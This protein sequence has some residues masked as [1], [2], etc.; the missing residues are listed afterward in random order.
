MQLVALAGAKQRAKDVCPSARESGRFAAGFV[1]G[2]AAAMPNT[3]AAEKIPS[4][5]S[6]SSFSSLAAIGIPGGRRKIQR[7]G[8]AAAAIASN[9]AFTRNSTSPS[10]A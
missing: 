6:S 3:I 10:G 5:S 1:M 2:S 9:R 8:H 7:S 4:A